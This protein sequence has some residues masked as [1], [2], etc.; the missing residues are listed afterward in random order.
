MRGNR[1]A[2]IGAN[3]RLPF[4]KGSKPLKRIFRGLD[5]DYRAFFE[6][7]SYNKKGATWE[8]GT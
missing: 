1:E 2:K 7:S 4:K 8:K 6:S 3:S 5:F